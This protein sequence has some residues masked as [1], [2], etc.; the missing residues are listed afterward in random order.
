MR[1]LL[2]LMMITNEGSV[3]FVVFHVMGFHARTKKEINDDEKLM[4]ITNE[5]S[6]INDD[7]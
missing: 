4:M 7:Y 5:G 3:I 6:V 1:A 2:L